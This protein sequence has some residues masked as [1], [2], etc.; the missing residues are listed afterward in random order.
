[1][2]EWVTPTRSRRQAKLR[3]FALHPQ[4]FAAR[5]VRRQRGNSRRNQVPVSAGVY[6]ERLGEL[7]VSL[8]TYGYDHD[9]VRHLGPMAQDFAKA[10]GLG[11]SDKRIDIL[12]ANGVLMVACQE[13]HR[14]V[15]DLE[16]RLAELESQ[17]AG[18]D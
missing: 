8:W 15:Q 13:L 4:A 3:A 5:L 7:P 18:G 11:D 14:R 9:S 12:D 17:R 1:M 16:T 10:F 2:S 6:L